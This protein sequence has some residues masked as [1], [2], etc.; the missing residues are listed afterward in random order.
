[1]LVH[2]TAYILITYDC[3]YY[4]RY[5]E[6]KAEKDGTSN[7]NTD[8]AKEAKPSDSPADTAMAVEPAPAAVAT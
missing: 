4:C 6:D 5:Y 2:T 7:K 8:A 1:M 3:Y